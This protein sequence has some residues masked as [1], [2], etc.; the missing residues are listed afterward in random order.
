VSPCE[1]KMLAIRLYQQR[2]CQKCKHPLSTWELLAM[3]LGSGFRSHVRVKT[4]CGKELVLP[5]ENVNPQIM[6]VLEEK[7]P[8]TA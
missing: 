2:C 5:V 7:S 6:D 1:R 4:E 8:P 3:L